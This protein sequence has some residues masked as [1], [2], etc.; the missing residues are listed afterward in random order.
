MNCS[1]TPVSSKTSST[2]VQ[3]LTKV[4]ANCARLDI[5]SCK[6]SVWKQVGKSLLPSPSDTTIELI[7]EFTVSAAAAQQIESEYDWTQIPRAAIHPRLL[8]IIP[9]GDYRSSA[10][11]DMSFSTNSTYVFGKALIGGPGA[12]TVYFIARDLDHPFQ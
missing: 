2:S 4:L 1:S 5:E 10:Q 6:F 8:A 11:F 7:G 9:A 12:R 3:A